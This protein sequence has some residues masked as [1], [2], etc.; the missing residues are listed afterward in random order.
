[1][2]HVRK[3]RLMGYSAGNSSGDRIAGRKAGPLAPASLSHA[4]IKDKLLLLAVGGCVVGTMCRRC[5]FCCAG[6]RMA[7]RRGVLPQLAPE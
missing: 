7:Y 6:G 5:W 4:G 1:M 3:G 2:E